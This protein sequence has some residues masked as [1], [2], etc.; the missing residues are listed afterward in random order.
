M[1]YLRRFRLAES[2]TGSRRSVTETDGSVDEEKASAASSPT[3]DK[4]LVAPKATP[5]DSRIDT[6]STSSSEESEECH[7]VVQAQAQLE[8]TSMQPEMLNASDDEKLR[9]A[10]LRQDKRVLLPANAPP[11]PTPEPNTSSSAA[12]ANQPA[13]S[14]ASVKLKKLCEPHRPRPALVKHLSESEHYDST[15]SDSQVS[16]SSASPSGTQLAGLAGSGI[17]LPARLPPRG[18]TRSEDWVAGLPNSSSCLPSVSMP[19]STACLLAPASGSDPLAVASAGP[20]RHS[21]PSLSLTLINPS[22]PLAKPVVPCRKCGLS[23]G[24]PTYF[25]KHSKFCHTGAH[26]LDMFVSPDEVPSPTGPLWRPVASLTQDSPTLHSPCPPS[27]PIFHFPKRT[28]KTRVPMQTAVATAEAF[29]VTDDEYDDEEE[30]TSQTKPL[31]SHPCHKCSPPQR[32]VR[33]SPGLTS[34]PELHARTP[35]TSAHLH[36]N[37]ASRA[38]A[39]NNGVRTQVPEPQLTY[40]SI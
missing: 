12:H 38:K 19:A 15:C 34:D 32:R 25:E 31:L 21:N 1:Q 2:C 5:E 13:S 4:K 16:Q 10:G 37:N 33:T 26:A 14:T 29:G 8:T 30:V 20:S 24:S 40:V 7:Q 28:G 3:K 39:T 9:L 6:Y 17:S 27:S 36:N 18:E 23:P 35:T 22:R 11:G